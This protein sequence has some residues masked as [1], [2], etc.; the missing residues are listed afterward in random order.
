LNCLYTNANS[1]LNKMTELR[2]RIHLEEID[3]IGITESW[4]N[5]YVNDAELYIEGFNMFR[6]DRNKIK[7][8]GLLLY[9]NA[10]LKA[11]LNTVLTNSDFEEALWC[12][13]QIDQQHLTVGLCYRSPASTADN[14]H[15]LLQMLEK[16]VIQSRPS[17]MLVMG[18]FNYPDVD[19]VNNLVTAGDSDPATLFFHKT[20]DLCLFQHVSEPTR[21]RQ[22]QVPSTLD[23]LFTSDDNLID[24][25]TY[26]TPLGK[27]DH[28]VLRWKLLLQ[29]CDIPSCQQK[30]NYYKGNYD[31]IQKNLSTIDWRQHWNGKAVTEMWADFKTTLTD[32]VHLHIPVK[33]ALNKKKR[34][35]SKKIRKLIKDRGKAWQKYCQNSSGKNFENYKRLRNEVN[36][37]I[38]QEE[39][40]TRKRILQ[41]FKGNPK[42]FYGYM[43]NKQSVKDNVT[44]LKKENGEMTTSDQETANLLSDY[45]KEVYTVEDANNLP[46]VQDS[47]YTWNDTE[48]QF[49]ESIVMGKLQKLKTDKSPGPDGIHPLLLKECASVLAE[50]LSLIYQKSYATGTLPTDWKTANIVPIYKKGSRCDKANYRPV[51]LTSVPCKIMENIIKEGLSKY[52]LTN[53]I[54]C[55]EQHGFTSG[56]SCLTNLLETFENWT[57]AL[58]EGYGLDVVYLDYRK[59][60][61]SV[62]HRR[63]LEKLK[64]VGING[65]LLLWLEDFLVSRTM[66]VGVRGTFSQLHAVL[67]GV[68]QGSVLGP[69]LFILFVNELPTWIVNEMKIFADDT[70]LWCRIK[71]ESDAVTLQQ[72][73]DRLSTWSNIWQLNFN[74]E[75]C[76]VMHI[77]HSCNTEYYMTEG[78]LRRKLE[79]V[80]QERDLGIIVSS[81]LKSSQQCIK[82]AATARRVIAM[83]RRNFKRLDVNDF[84]LIYKTYIRPHLEYCIQV[85][86]PYLVKDI[87]VLERVQK[88]ATNLI[89]QLR[90]YSYADRLKVLGLTSLKDRRER[91]DMIEVYKILNG[92]EH[93]DSGQFFEPAENH[94]CLRGHELKL[95]KERSRLDIR[96]HSFSQRIVNSWNSL[97]ASVVNAKSVNEFKNAYDRN[98]CNDMDVRSR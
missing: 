77:G 98:Y 90:K 63:L 15:K 41:G 50:P 8:G 65:K 16:A 74:T 21:I 14:N 87:E 23:Y 33:A 36:S 51:S 49:S 47:V 5:D 17:H 73:I 91:G 54:P 64:G 85:W 43:R 75:K 86:S 32:Q 30:L 22:H 28:V 20:H 10:R 92:K 37:K 27:S 68:P 56:R 80:Q 82:A 44:S 26:D 1:V 38:R 40:C 45:F 9:V 88:A 53:A 89:P 76:K 62:P 35:L 70:K 60:F 96:K 42:R 72:D 55:K 11:S 78:S 79:C 6:K 52:L 46:T 67:S 4:A 94:Y 29:V 84:N 34:Y 25:V 61:D 19:Y 3:L 71:K 39:E 58:D 66:K 57:K 59:A 93:I 31:A 48:L 83:V 81:N 95:T 24:E 12:N 18:D 7:G 97:P 69:L 2:E 13:L